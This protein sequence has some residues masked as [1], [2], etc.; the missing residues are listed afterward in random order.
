MFKVIYLIRRR[1]DLTREAFA[2]Y[3]RGTHVPL[4]EM[5]PNLRK[6]TINLVQ[7]VDETEPD[8]D[9][10][11]ELWF[12]DVA[13]F[14]AAHATDEASRASADH[15]NFVEIEHTRIMVVEEDIV[16]A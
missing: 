12:D 2:R 3:C 5:I 4:V 8:C 6:L 16:R 9:G 14:Q 11:V 15:T 13:A 7:P 10:V 1:K